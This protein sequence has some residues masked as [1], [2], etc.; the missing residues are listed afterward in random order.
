LTRCKHCR[1]FFLTHPRNAGRNDLR[2]PFGCRQAHRKESS[3]KRSSEYYQS[4][5]GKKKKKAHNR[6]RRL[7]VEP[8]QVEPDNGSDDLINDE[9]TGQQEEVVRDKVTLSYIQML[10]SLIE[11]HLVSLDEVLKMV[12]KIMRQHSIGKRRR[13]VYAFTYPS[14]K[15]P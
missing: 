2:C 6:R 1:I 5:E 14:S 13:F 7:Q 12:H 9:S 4:E 11:G 15:P 3:N 8:D 10:V